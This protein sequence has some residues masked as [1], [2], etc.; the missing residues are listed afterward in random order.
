VAANADPRATFR[1][2]MPPEPPYCLRPTDSNHIRTP[3]ITIRPH[4]LCNFTVDSYILPERDERATPLD[5][6]FAFAA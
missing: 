3:L 5:F 1:R 6:N 2:L 4:M